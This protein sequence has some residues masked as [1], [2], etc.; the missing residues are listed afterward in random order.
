MSGS[1]NVSLP[2]SSGKAAARAVPYSGETA[3][4]Q[5]VGIVTFEGADDAKTATDV[6]PN[7]PFPVEASGVNQILLALSHIANILESNTIVDSA[8]RQRVT[9]DAI[10]NGLTL[11]TVST[12]GS[13]ITLPNLPSIAGMDREMYINIA[14]QTYAQNIL[15]NL[16]FA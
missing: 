16:T 12:V 10:A 2:A 11:A 4:A 8:Q 15:Q 1:D 5:A 14:E 9:L 13:I 6:G 7:N 3:L